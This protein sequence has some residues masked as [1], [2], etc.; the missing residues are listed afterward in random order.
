MEDV[1]VKD[2]VVQIDYVLP[3]IGTKLFNFITIANLYYCFLFTENLPNAYIAG[4]K[5]F[6]IQ[7]DPSHSFHWNECGLQ[8]SCPQ[9]ALSSSDERCEVAIVALAGGQFTLP[10]RTKLVSAV[11]VIS[12]SNPRLKSLTLKLQH[13]VALETKDQAD[14]LKFVRA[15]HVEFGSNADFT[16]LE[17]GE[18]CPG[19]WYGSIT[20]HHFCGLGVVQEEISA[21]QSTGI[22][23]PIVLHIIILS[24]NYN[25]CY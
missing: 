19:S 20:R 16:I 1:K 4:Q 11:Y 13:C 6:V 17:E 23:N 2:T 25:R 8:L 9:G 18:F 15:S 14:R 24:M 10:A 7:G 5:L 22:T 21:E 12:V 3:L